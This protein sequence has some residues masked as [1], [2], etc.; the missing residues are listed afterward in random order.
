MFIGISYKISLTSI[1]FIVLTRLKQ[2]CSLTKSL[3]ARN[4]RLRF[5]Y[6][7]YTNFL[8]F[9]LYL[10]TAYSAHYIVEKNM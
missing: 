1:S 4:V 2:G 8:Y 5:P 10:N 9:A 6:R 7:L 3:Y